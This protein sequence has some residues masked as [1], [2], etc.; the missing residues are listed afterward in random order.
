MTTAESIRLW[1][2]TRRAGQEARD[3]GAYII[4]ILSQRGKRAAAGRTPKN[5]RRG[6]SEYYRQLRLGKGRD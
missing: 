6:G 1:L 3:L 2:D 5:M 4:E